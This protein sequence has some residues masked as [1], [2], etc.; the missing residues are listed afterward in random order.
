MLAA[1]VLLI[2]AAFWPGHMSN[3]TLA[4]IGEVQ[5]GR[6]TN[7]LSPVLAI[8]WHP[9]YRLGFG[10][11]WVLTAQVA[12]FVAGT[13][14]VARATL[15][16]VAATAAAVAVPLLPMVFGM[17][18][19][20]SRDT[21]FTVLLVLTFGLLTRAIQ[22]R[23]RARWALAV[24]ALVAGWLTLAA[25]QNA[26]P[27]VL[28]ACAVLAGLGLGARGLLRSSWGPLRR[29]AAATA[30]G[31]VLTVALLGTQSALT[32]AAGVTDVNPEQYLYA[33]D[34]AALSVDERRNLF[35][36]DVMPQRGLQVVQSH[37]NVDSN[38][39]LFWTPDAPVRTPLSPPAFASLRGAWRDAV[40]HHPAEYAGN[41]LE[42]YLRQLTFGHPAVF[43]YHP[44][45]D[46]NSFGFRVRFARLNQAARD[47]MAAFTNPANDGDVLFTVWAYLLAALVLAAL[48]LRRGI[49]APA[50]VAGLLALGG[51]LYQSGLLLG[52]MGL[53]Y[54]FE[55]PA[56]ATTLV[57][58]AAA[59]GLLARRR[60][61]TP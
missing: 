5:T 16:R 22:L 45:I 36:A 43:V 47:Y 8:L 2:A 6:Y 18:G 42:L 57:V 17:L 59:L 14:L 13:Y 53:Q 10:P 51:I 33:Y 61:A 31:L 55:F 11:G 41:R 7:Q 21:W 44:Q 46:A 12:C 58:A 27:A 24:A 60:A 25:R 49:A 35:P 54:R 15:G 30:A 50:R 19:Y 40:A 39:P 4:Q 28:P 37:Y 52:P 23:G 29:A 20:L 26:A 32:S 34:L 48:L 1:P 38:V 56:V 9:L 3:D